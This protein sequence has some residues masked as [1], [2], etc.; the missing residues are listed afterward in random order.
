[1]AA[2]TQETLRVSG[3][4]A[5][6]ERSLSRKLFTR[7]LILF[8]SPLLLLLVI[9]EMLLW[10]CGETLNIENVIGY[11]QRVPDALFLRGMLDQ[12][13]YRYK[14]LN[15]LKRHPK[16]L[17]I[18]SS[19]VME[20]RATMFGR[21]QGEFYNAGGLIQNLGDLKGFVEALPPEDSPRVILLGLDLWWFNPSQ[22]MVEGFSSGVKED[23]ANN[24]QEHVRL[25]RKFKRKRA[26]RSVFEAALAKNPNIGIEARN[27]RAGFRSDGS[28][29]Y[30]FRIP[31]TLRE[32]EFVDREKP[33]IAG[34]IRR[35]M[36][37]FPP[38]HGISDERLALLDECLKELSGRGVLVAGILPPFSSESLN[39]LMQKP[40]HAEL[41]NQFDQRVP[42][43]FEKYKQPL[44]DGSNLTSLGLN[45]SYLLDGIHG[46]ET[47]QL[48]ILLR[49]LDDP[50][51]E[52]EL[53]GLKSSVEAA[54][55]SKASN[56]W[57]PDYTAMTRRLDN[58][59]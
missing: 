38:S 11:Q 52:R 31:Q 29:E 13:F 6:E 18:G 8:V 33:P 37:P 44:V 21:Y 40:E 14:F 20:F 9:I 39:L 30:N 2:D 22:P 10:K 47:Y 32:W 7:R 49:M 25:W 15:I 54:L 51:V 12:A 3:V 50:R 41:W 24:W 48:Q 1:M 57:Q 45:D 46:A 53:D 5:A 56:A 36:S 17:A 19:R 43:I 58:K 28:M 26:W 59:N 35:G 42:E 16:I 34:R 27:Q 55:H 23:P 4:C